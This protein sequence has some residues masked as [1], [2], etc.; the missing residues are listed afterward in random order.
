MFLR[1]IKSY[2][3]VVECHSFTEAAK[4]CNVSQSAISQQIQ[5]LEDELGVSLIVRSNRGFSLTPAGKFFYDGGLKLLNVVGRY[6][7]A[8]RAVATKEVDITLAVLEDFAGRDLDKTVSEFM[9][10]YHNCSIDVKPLSIH[11]LEADFEERQSDVYLSFG[12]RTVPEGYAE[13]EIGKLTCVAEINSSDPLAGLV[14][15]SPSDLSGYACV[16]VAGSDDASAP[17]GFYAGFL[18]EGAKITV[19]KDED[20]AAEK[21]SGGGAFRPVP[22]GPYSPLAW[23]EGV[24][25]VDM[26]D[27]RGNLLTIPLT[28]Y[29]RV[30]ENGDYIAEF[31]SLMKRR[32]EK[33]K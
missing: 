3:T 24:K 26:R 16:L 31:L 7:D 12:G 28:V 14:S 9:S 1:Q 32:T 23:S 15:V 29:Y 4:I 19:V 18:G 6:M 10:L 2:I 30:G 33:N 21:I 13:E 8:T 27:S 22:F 5:G 11:A 25:Y 17:R 20:E